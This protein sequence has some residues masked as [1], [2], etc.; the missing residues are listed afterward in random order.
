MIAQR[1]P[2][3]LKG[4]ACAARKSLPGNVKFDC[5]GENYEPG[6]KNPQGGRR[7]PRGVKRSA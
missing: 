6:W 1:P 7:Q 3:L 2:T 4:N 5:V